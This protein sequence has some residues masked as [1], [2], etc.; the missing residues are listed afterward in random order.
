[1]TCCR[2]LC[3]CRFTM[4]YVGWQFDK[5]CGNLRHRRP[6]HRPAPGKTFSSQMSA[7]T[8]RS[9][10]LSQS[11]TS[12]STMQRLL[13]Q[14]QKQVQR[15]KMRRSHTSARAAYCKGVSKSWL[16][17]YWRQATHAFEVYCGHKQTALTASCSLNLTLPVNDCC[18]GRPTVLLLLLHCLLRTGAQAAAGLDGQSLASPQGQKKQ[19]TFPALGKHSQTC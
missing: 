15:R 1:M 4:G 7:T 5:L 19:R 11:V 18:H 14:N 6:A 10:S 2:T 13:T 8:S 17:S 12:T 3:F 16:G 9:L